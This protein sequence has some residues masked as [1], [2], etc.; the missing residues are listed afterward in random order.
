MPDQ[1]TYM[2]ALQAA[3]WEFEEP[4]RDY[5]KKTG[6]TRDA[7]KCGDRSIRESATRFLTLFEKFKAEYPAVPGMEWGISMPSGLPRQFE[8]SKPSEPQFRPSA[9][10]R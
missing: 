10:S 5:R 8:L 3:Y 9:S 7:S 2:A 6:D 1:S 4:W